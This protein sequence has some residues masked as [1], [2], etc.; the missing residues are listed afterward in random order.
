MKRFLVLVVLGVMTAVMGNAYADQKVVGY[1][2]SPEGD[3]QK[4]RTTDQT[5]LATDSAS[6]TAQVGIGTQTPSTD[7]KLDVVG[8]VKVTE[9]Q[10]VNG[11]QG[12]DRVLVSDADGNARWAQPPSSNLTAGNTGYADW[13]LKASFIKGIG[14]GPNQT[15]PLTLSTS[16]CASTTGAA[17]CSAHHT[18]AIVA[19]LNCSDGR[20]MLTFLKQTTA[21]QDGITWHYRS[22]C[23][24]G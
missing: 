9:L 17:E 22:Y 8:K 16:F 24:A 3:Y 13:L 23:V 12:A 5:L 11:T 19:S 1:V 14:M 21:D 18:Y 15:P 6:S 7:T 10:I 4:L 20:S 2:P